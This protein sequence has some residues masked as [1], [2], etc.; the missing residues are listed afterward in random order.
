MAKR[1]APD[2]PVRQKIEPIVPW[3]R[4]A[5]V[6]PE[7]F[8]L[9]YDGVYLGKDTEP[10]FICGPCW[11]ASETR[12]SSGGDW[13][14]VVHWIDRDKN[15]RNLAFPSR[16][17]FERGAPIVGDLAAHGLRVVPGRERLLV[18]YLGQ[19]VLPEMFRHRAVSQLGWATDHDDALVYVLPDRVIGAP[20][21]DVVFQPEE[22]APTTRTMHARGT[23]KQWQK[24]VAEPCRNN[25][26]LAFAVCAAFA[27]PLLKFAGLEC[28]GFHLYGR[29]S[30]GKTTA[31][32]VAATVW[33]SGGDPSEDEGSFISR[34]NTTGNALEGI[35]AAHNDGFLALDEMGT[36]DARDFGKVVYDLHGG[37]G[38]SRM[39]KTAALQASRTWRLLSVSTGEISVRQKIEENSGRKARAGQLVRLA[40]IPIGNG[41]I[42][43]V[44]EPGR[45]KFIDDLKRHSGRYF[46]TVG[47]AFLEALIS[48]HQEVPRLHFAVQ[49]AVDDF[50]RELVGELELESHQ[51]RVVRRFAAVAAAGTFA[52]LFGVLPYENSDIFRAVET[53]MHAWLGDRSNRAEAELGVEAVRDFIL[54]NPN[55]FR[56]ANDDRAFVHSPIAGYRTSDGLF[57]FIEAGLR[58]ACAGF[59]MPTVLEEL[60]RQGHLHTSESSRKKS[61]HSV[62]GEGR[63][64][65]YAV[66][67]SLLNDGGEDA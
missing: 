1:A 21:E 67:T 61:K 7:G 25:P 24:F 64:R 55:R 34:W 60:Q 26:M 66:K 16:K 59:D 29:T 58:E 35:A 47:P 15:E 12:S 10:E 48:E 17:L 3:L 19:Y 18:R 13:G 63:L 23:L 51:R 33:G 22:H 2:Y 11:V 27:G 38:K 46:G 32:Q 56:P 50:E 49:S 42:I 28:G 44:P 57:L 43:S 20:A 52:S 30:K 54:R 39:T 4:V 65:L 8:K 40:D 9:N 37:K 5:D 14:V 45:G 36:C 31:L 41:L 53:A 62:V 6:V